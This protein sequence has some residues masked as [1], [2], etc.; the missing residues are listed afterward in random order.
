MVLSG[1]KY[2]GQITSYFTTPFNHER[3]AAGFAKSIKQHNDNALYFTP[4]KY[5]PWKPN[6]I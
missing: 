5:W 3:T 1:G 2:I 4:G 6:G